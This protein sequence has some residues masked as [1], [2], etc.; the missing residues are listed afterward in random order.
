MFRPQEGAG[1]T[2]GETQVDGVGVQVGNTPSKLMFV[3]FTLAEV[4]VENGGWVR[5]SHCRKWG[6][7]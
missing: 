5:E 2:L 4:T 7:G 1:N 3:K 6:L